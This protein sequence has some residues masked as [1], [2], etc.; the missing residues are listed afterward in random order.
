MTS[1]L[2]RFL[3]R[4]SFPESIDNKAI[5]S[6]ASIVQSIYAYFPLS[7]PIVSTGAPCGIRPR[8]QVYDLTT[9][10]SFLIRTV[11]TWMPSSISPRTATGHPVA[12]TAIEGRLVPLTLQRENVSTATGR[13]Y[14]P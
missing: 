14:F 5:T 9:N 3:Y 12:M 8:G 4:P 13:L 7:S 6:T 11:T 2:T 1:T 10:P